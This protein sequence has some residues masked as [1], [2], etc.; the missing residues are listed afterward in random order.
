MSLR[1]PLFRLF[2]YA[3]PHRAR[4]RAAVTCSVLNKL[5]DLAPP[6][7]IGAAIDV[8]VNQEQSLLAGYGV[9]DVMDQL[10]VLTVL[11]FLIWG[12]E[13]VFEYL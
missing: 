9:V 1:S 13:S 10:I 5:F 4:I 3:K 8:V 2:D 11:T 7:L 12:A 6:A